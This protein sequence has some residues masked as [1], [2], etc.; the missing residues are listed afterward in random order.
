MLKA[1]IFVWI[2]DAIVGFTVSGQSKGKSGCFFL[3]GWNCIS[4][5]SIIQKIGVHVTPM[6]LEEKT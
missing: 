1:I 2:H 6:V 4:L 5:P 3:R